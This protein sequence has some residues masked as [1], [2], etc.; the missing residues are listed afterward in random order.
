MSALSSPLMI[1]GAANPGG[2]QISMPAPFSGSG[3]GGQ[4]PYLPMN[5]TQPQPVAS[6]AN[7]Y[8]GSFGAY[9]FN[10]TGTTTPGG[11]TTVAP[12]TNIGT[13][14]TGSTASNTNSSAL[15]RNLDKTF[16]AGIGGMLQNFLTSGAGYNPQVLQQLFAQLQPQFANQQ[17]NLLQQFSASGNRFG[18]GAQ[19][20]YADLLGQQ[21]LTEGDVAANLYEQ[22]I[23]NFMSIITNAG[24]TTAQRIESTPS[25]FDNA[26]ALI[27]ALKPGGGGGGQEAAAAAAGA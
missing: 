13:T 17:Q 16:G 8:A 14:G 3:A 10:P 18:S 2:S 21:S 6:S 1:P 22:S 27:N 25:G 24:D 12:S 26:M 20:G 23:Q 9:G 7:P 15:S 4:N 5:S 19:T 11:G